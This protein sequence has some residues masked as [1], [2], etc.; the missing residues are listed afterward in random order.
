MKT[1]ATIMVVDDT[2]A[3]LRMMVNIL[4]AEGYRVLPAED[5]RLALDAVAATVPDLILLD[6]LMPGMDGFEVLRRLKADERTRH[7]PVI[8]LSA[9]TDQKERIDGFK[10]GAVDFISK[11]FQQE[12]L[13]AR[14]GT[15]VELFRLRQ[16][17]ADEVAQR[18]MAL[19]ES[20]RRFR[21]TFEQ[22]AVG[23]AHVAPDG[24]W[25][26]A[27]RRLCE[28][29]GYSRDDLRGMTFQD[30]THPDDLD[31]DFALVRQV[32]AGEI[33]SYTM[34][35]R[36]L[37]RDKSQIWTNLTVALVRDDGGNPDYFISVVEDISKRKLAEQRLTDTVDALIRSNS[38]LERFAYVASHDLQEPIRTV[39]AFSQMLG[40]EIGET[41]SPAIR[42]CLDYIISGAKR[43]H[44]LI[45]DLLAYSRTTGRD[46]P[47]LQ[48]DCNVVLE[49]ALL[50]LRA[51][52][53]ES[54]ADIVVDPLPTVE[55]N[56]TQI[57]ELFQN[58][59][60]NG[61][62]FA[63]RDAP[64][65]IRV[66]ATHGERGWVFSVADNGIGISSDYHDQIF[67][68]F[69][70]LHPSNIYP[71][72]GLGLALCKRIVERRGGRIWVES[73]PGKGSTFF[74][75]LDD[76]PTPAQAATPLATKETDPRNPKACS[77]TP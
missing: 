60:A 59:I 8:F 15:H 50:N 12:E 17:L 57:M 40:R 5:G 23:I 35:K 44:D 42:E 68:L 6:I 69:R 61:I 52:I 65:R 53:E 76:G 48:V 47:M 62:K 32:L 73:E 1:M 43:M 58:L 2:I 36:Y 11:P 19:S 28:I 49:A 67:I 66:S 70:R 13:L 18:T 41:G 37:R 3:S 24:R 54:G 31:A 45:C 26:R 10:L 75:T 46:M 63:R 27:N 72:T 56:S 34:E 21:A 51:M 9:V 33:E 29:V 25:L 77:L 22:A 74:F 38:E 71:G 39:V 14:I 64:P 7:V 20:E 16:H 55:G 4:Q 30:I